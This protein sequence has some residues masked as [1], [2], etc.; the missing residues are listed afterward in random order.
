MM[1]KVNIGIK[2]TQDLYHNI[3][4]LLDAAKELGTIKEKNDYF[5]ITY[6]YFEE[7]LRRKE[8]T[9]TEL[10]P[11][12]NEIERAT[13]II[14][15][16][17]MN[18]MDSHENIIKLADIKYKEVLSEK[19]RKIQALTSLLEKV[20]HENM[21]LQTVD[22]E[23]I[24]LKN[25][26]VQLESKIT[27]IELRHEKELNKLDREYVRKFSNFQSIFNEKLNEVN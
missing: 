11:T 12:L 26:I 17:F 18:M 22:E 1:S 16:Q 24:Q 19:D 3:H 20:E 8:L 23:N 4:G 5:E 13:T 6:P 25:E 27:K 10:G 9:Q 7:Y 15:K 14:I 21:R 2:T